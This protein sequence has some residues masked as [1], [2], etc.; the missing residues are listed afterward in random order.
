MLG[1]DVFRMLPIQ[2]GQKEQIKNLVENL[3][4]PDFKEKKRKN[5]TYN[6][7]IPHKTVFPFERRTS[8]TFWKSNAIGLY[9]TLF[10]PF[11]CKNESFDLLLRQIANNPSWE[12]IFSCLL[13]YNKDTGFFSTRSNSSFSL[14]GCY[15]SSFH[16]FKAHIPFC[17]FNSI[18]LLFPLLS[19]LLFVN[20]KGLFPCF[21]H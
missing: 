20:F 17:N 2:Y 14:F 21:C 6:A 9:N 11:V 18:L 12:G 1:V 10:N 5:W 13:S 8:E 7:H 3:A 15:H 16:L 4:N 19:S